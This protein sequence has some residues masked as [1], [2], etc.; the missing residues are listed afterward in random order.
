MDVTN[1]CGVLFLRNCPPRE[2]CKNKLLRKVNRFPVSSDKRQHTVTLK[3][4]FS[5]YHSHPKFS[6]RKVWTI[7]IFHGCE[8]LTE[9]SVM[10]VT[11]QHHKACRVM[12]NNYPNDGIFNLHQRTIMDS[13]F[14]H[15]LPWTIAFRF[16]YM[17]FYQ[18]YAKITTFF[19]Q[20]KF[21][22]AP[23]LYV[24]VQTFG[25]N[26]RENDVKSNVRIVILMSCTR[27]IL[28]PSYKTTFL[29]PGW[30]YGNP[31][32]VCKKNRVDPDQTARAILSV[33]FGCITVL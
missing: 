25:G 6:H 22:V 28:H 1:F 12:P 14:L 5:C 7:R 33:P 2:Y 17:L 3:S 24:D 18:F 32:Q 26:R 31:G 30:V 10:R 16:E 29:S 4:Q 20:E 21:G 19:D 13:F 9:I 11:V 27:F 8:L 15:S 23:V